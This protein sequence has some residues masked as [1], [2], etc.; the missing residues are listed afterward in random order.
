MRSIN[1]ELHA[2]NV[3]L[4][5]K[6]DELDRAHNDLRN[7]FDSTQIAT[8]FLDQHLVIRSFTPSITSIFNLSSN[9]CGRPLTDIVSQ[10]DNSELR[11]EIEQVF[12]RDEPFEKNVSNREKS[13]HYLMRIL[14]YKRDRGVIEGVLVTFVDITNLKEAEDK[15]RLM[16]AELNHRVRN[17]LT[18]VNAITRATLTRSVSKEAFAESLSGRIQA[19]GTAYTLVSRE[20]WGEVELNSIII[21]QLM[22]FQSDSKHR[23]Q[24]AGPCVLC[25]PNVAVTFGLIVHEL[26]TNA[27][28]YGALS[29]ARGS[30]SINWA[31]DSSGTSALIF[32][33]REQGG[34]PTST[35]SRKGFGT[36]LI[37]RELKFSLGAKLD[38]QFLPDGVALKIEI[39]LNST[40]ITLPSE[41]SFVAS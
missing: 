13:T 2:A 34:P 33:W 25:K 40:R 8:V 7:L 5:N 28:K 16:V 14:P 17:M 18:V 36:E 24:I 12:E 37:E 1:E 31:V 30:V 21:D 39:P 19:M 3:E 32:Q 6:I 22:P 35:P 15:Q 26:A 11:A 10:I 38:W 41:H 27:V 9:D 20:Q 29:N 23:I 4:S